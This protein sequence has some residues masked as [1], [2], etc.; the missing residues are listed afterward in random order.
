M[1]KTLLPLGNKQY[2]TNMG[3]DG[4]QVNVF[5]IHILKHDHNDKNY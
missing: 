1:G 3:V 4:K 5:N 2:D